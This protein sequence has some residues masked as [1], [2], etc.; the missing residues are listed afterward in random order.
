SPQCNTKLI[1]TGPFELVS[2]KFGDKFVAKR[3]PNYWYHG[4]KG[5]EQ[6]PYLD[7]ITYVPIE[8]GPSRLTALESGDLQAMHTSDAL[9]ILKLRNHIKNGSLRDIE[10]DKYTELGY[11]MLNAT[12]PPFNYLSARQAFAYAIDRD[13]YNKLRNGGILTNASGPFSPGT[14]GHLPDPG[15]IQFN[16][17]AAKA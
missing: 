1:G 16:P 17:T 15:P 2:W 3:N 14:P 5:D 13:T 8:D 6:L 10:S 7:Q 4:P 9:Q 12:K 11:V